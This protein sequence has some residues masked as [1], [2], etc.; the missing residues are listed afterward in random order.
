MHV[1]FS[2]PTYECKRVYFNHNIICLFQ[3]EFAFI[4]DYHNIRFRF[5]RHNN[6]HD[7][8]KY[9]PT[10]PQL[11]EWTMCLWVNMYTVRATHL[12]SYAY[13]GQFNGVII[14]IDS[15]TRLRVTIHGQNYYC[16]DP[17]FN[18]QPNQNV[19]YTNIS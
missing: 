15:T 7:W 10:V 14:A 18:F 4:T 5:P 1:F 19:S 13:S 16:D 2:K 9:L 8:V 6:V 17:S 11:K 3:M 12:V